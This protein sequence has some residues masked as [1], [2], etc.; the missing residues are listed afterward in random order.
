M[1]HLEASKHG[2]TDILQSAPAELFEKYPNNT[3]II[4]ASEL[5]V[6]VPSALQKHC[7]SYSA[8]KSHTTLKCLL[9]AD[10]KGGKMFMSQLYEGPISDKQVVQRSGFL[11]ILDKNVMVGEKKGDTI[12]ADKGFEFQNDLKK[13]GLQLNI[14]PYL[15]VFKMMLL[16]PNQLQAAAYV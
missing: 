13:L 11:D 5:T 4:D 12:M 2:H 8:Y 16:K 10:P 1:S 3:V 6:K 7:E 14:P 9:G 15:K